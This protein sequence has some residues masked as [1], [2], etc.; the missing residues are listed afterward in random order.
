MNKVKNILLILPTILV[1]LLIF[2]ECDKPAPLTPAPKINVD[3]LKKEIR[4]QV[5]ERN[6][7]LKLAQVQDST[8]VKYVTKWRSVRT[9]I[10]DTVIHQ[11]SVIKLVQTCDSVIAYDSLQISTLRA[12]NQKADTVIMNYQKVVHADSLTAK[13]LCDSISGLRKEVRKQK[14]QKR[15]IIAAWILREVAGIIK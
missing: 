5:E 15:G 11:D 3:S 4:N 12:A 13:H 1:C 8:R 2:R 9:I 10:H 6:S 14:W 7:L